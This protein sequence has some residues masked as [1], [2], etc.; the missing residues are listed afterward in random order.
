MEIAD[1]GSLVVEIDVPE[2]RLSLI[3]P[4]G[5]TE[6]VLDAFAGRRFRGKVREL[7]RRVNRAKATVPVK[8]EITEDSADV[9]PD[10]SARVSFLAQEVDESRKDEPSKLLVSKDAVVSRDGKSAVFVVKEG[11]VKLEPVELGPA[12]G[13][14]VELLR[15][16]PGGTKVV[17]HPEATL[18]SG[19]R[20][21]ERTE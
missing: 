19:Q 10:M 7:G 20:I 8:V 4:G 21:K 12:S 13:D 2:A 9:L 6:I 17:R 14:S 11:A 18:Q 5:P 16:P 3:K 15:G 1:L